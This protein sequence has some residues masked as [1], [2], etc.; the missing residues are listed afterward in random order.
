M[1]EA[2]IKK[3][4]SQVVNSQEPENFKSMAADFSKEIGYGAANLN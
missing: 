4:P 1:R 2:I 3:N